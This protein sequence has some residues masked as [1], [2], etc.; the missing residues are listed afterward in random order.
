MLFEFRG[1]NFKC[2]RDEQVLSAVASSD[3]SLPEKLIPDNEKSKLCLLLG[4]VMFPIIEQGGLLIVEELNASL[5]LLLVR[6][7]VEIFHSP[8]INRNNKPASQKFLGGGL[9]LST[10]KALSPGESYAS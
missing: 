10:G 2:F 3:D 6:A 1:K 9:M 5:H 4:N 7:L 8:E